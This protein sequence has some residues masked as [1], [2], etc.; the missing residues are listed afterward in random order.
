MSQFQLFDIVQLTESIA[1]SGDFSNRANEANQPE[2]APAGTVGTVVE[3]FKDGE[4]YLVELLGDWIKVSELGL[5]AA[6][7]QDSDAFRETIG[8]ETV[9]PHQLG[10]VKSAKGPEQEVVA[11]T[12]FG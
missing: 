11:R 6:T 8:L 3:V 9:Y 1:L 4:A 10:L 2:A 7:A 5:V 12:Q